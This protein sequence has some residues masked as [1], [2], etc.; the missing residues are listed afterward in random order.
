M[1]L[2]KLWHERLAHANV[3]TLMQHKASIKAIEFQQIFVCISFL[4]CC[5]FNEFAIIPRT[6]V[7]INRVWACAVWGISFWS[8]QFSVW[9]FPGISSAV[10]QMTGDLCTAPGI[11]SLF[12]LSLVDRHDWRDT[13]GKW[14][15][16]RNPDRSLKFFFWP[17]PMATWITDQQGVMIIFINHS[18]LQGSL[19]RYGYDAAV[20]QSST[21]SVHIVEVT[22]DVLSNK[23]QISGN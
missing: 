23:R 10:R 2:V 16:A 13:R 15:L 17:Q 19:L 4:C 1:E 7:F 6:P 12:P 18:S 5:T 3:L 8:Y 11:I 14:S 22:L 9:R 20:V 21:K